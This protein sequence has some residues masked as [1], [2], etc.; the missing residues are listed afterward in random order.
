VRDALF[1]I[2]GTSIAGAAVLDLFAGTGG[3]GL[4]ALRRGAASAVFVEHDRRHATAI[5][6]S[7]RRQ[8]LAD[9]AEVRADDAVNA[10]EVL[11]RAGRTF[12]LILLDPPYGAGWLDRALAVIAGRRLLAAGGDIVAEGHWRDRPALPAG[13]VLRR[14]ERYGETVLWFVRAEPHR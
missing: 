10:V 4:E 13:L 14:E 3:L 1:N 5:L 11:A 12:N 2:V 6:D 9:R 8:Q 7:L